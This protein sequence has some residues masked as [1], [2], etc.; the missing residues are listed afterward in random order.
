MIDLAMITI[1]NYELGNIDYLIFDALSRSCLPSLSFP[2]A[3]DDCPLNVNA[4]FLLSLSEDT[5]KQFVIA[6]IQSS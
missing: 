6:S 2:M 1:I 4:F 5:D 3:I